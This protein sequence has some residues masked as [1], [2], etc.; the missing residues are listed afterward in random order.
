MALFTPLDELKLIAGNGR[1]KKR[2]NYFYDNDIG[3]FGYEMGHP[4]K[5]QRIRL[6]HSLVMTYDLYQGMEV[7]VRAPVC[8]AFDI[9]LR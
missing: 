9:Y 4:M 8:P 5:P 3:N 1:D 2:V 7:Y 6:T